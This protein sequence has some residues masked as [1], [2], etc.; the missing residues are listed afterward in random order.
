MIG[1]SILRRTYKSVNPL[2][3][4]E[5]PLKYADYSTEADGYTKTWKVLVATAFTVFLFDNTYDLTRPTQ[6]HLTVA[7]HGSPI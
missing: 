5:E 3:R 2:Y 7:G 4:H 6:T 1:R